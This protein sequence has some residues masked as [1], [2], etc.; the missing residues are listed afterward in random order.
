MNDLI[1]DAEVII[2]TIDNGTVD[3]DVEIVESKSQAEMLRFNTFKFLQSQMKDI[4][5]YRNVINNALKSLDDRILKNELDAKDTLQV[6]NSLTTQITDKTSVL[7][8]PF[9]APAT[10]STLL[11]PPKEDSDSSF[12]KGVKDMSTEDLQL[13]N[14]FIRSI[15]KIKED[16]KQENEQEQE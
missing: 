12:E 7:L 6:I 10:G 14:K 16:L 2:S 13:F 11:T 9:R 1:N 8:A 5:Q 4:E 15:E 3:K